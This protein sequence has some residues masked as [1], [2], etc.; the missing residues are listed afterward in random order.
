MSL[1]VPIIVRNAVKLR[2]PLSRVVWGV[3]GLAD[4]VVVSVD[5]ESEDDSL[6]YV[7]DIMLE[8]N[9]KYPGLVRYIESEWDMGN[10]SS[11]GLEFA[12]QTNI[13][14]D[15]CKG[16]WIFSIQA[17]ESIHENDFGEIKKLIKE[18]DSMDIDAYF[19][20][21]LYF[22]GDMDTIRDDWTVPIVRLFR[23]GTRVSC[24]DAMNT[25]GSDKVSYCDVP[26]YHYSRIGDPDII[27]KR[28][29]SLDKFFHP[30]EKLLEEHELKPY[31]FNTRNFDCMHKDGVDVGK[32]E[33]GEV[34]SI[35]TGTHPKAFA[36][37]RGWV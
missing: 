26:I 16:D 15:N 29:L 27:S 19:M 14:I 28:I 4:E 21:R 12:R 3:I 24:G 11:T 9:A 18:A 8:I 33:V 22:Y 23:K 20:T 17:D 36:G 34:F 37:Y 35:F 25:S 5:P 30:R 10:V 31:D 1:S 32:K 6:D 7:Y 2:Y 13:A